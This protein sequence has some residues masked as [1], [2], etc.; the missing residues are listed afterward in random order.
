MKG[1]RT[2]VTGIAVAI[3][4]TALTYLV[5]IDWTQHVGPNVALGISGLLTV[6]LRMLTNT[7]A[8]QA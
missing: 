8:G 4:P 5:G 3:L 7:P 6:G 1:F 2:I